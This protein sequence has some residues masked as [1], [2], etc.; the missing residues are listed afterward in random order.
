M[1]M[2]ATALRTWQ[3]ATGVVFTGLAAGSR[4][5]RGVL[6]VFT[7]SRFLHRTAAIPLFFVCLKSAGAHVLVLGILLPRNG[8]QRSSL[9]GRQ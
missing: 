9:A 6:L 5:G 1:T 7:V 8:G 2:R 4:S 3:I